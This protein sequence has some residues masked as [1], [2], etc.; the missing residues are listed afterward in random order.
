MNKLQKLKLQIKNEKN[1]SEI[2]NSLVEDL[3]FLRNQLRD[4]KKFEESD[5]IRN[6]L[7]KSKYSYRRR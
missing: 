4:S 3:I 7:E 2:F 1:Y 5:N 6:L